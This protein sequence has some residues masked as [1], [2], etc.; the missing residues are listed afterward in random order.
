MS[1]RA[2]DPPPDAP[3][4]RDAEAGEA[5]VE[6]YRRLAD[7]FHD[8]LSEQSL[9]AFLERIADT[10]AEL[11]P[12]DDLAIYEADEARR[13]LRAVFARGPWADEVLADAPFRFGEG[14][15]GWAVEHREPLLVNRADLDPRVRFV[16]NT[17][18]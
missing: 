9:D 7:V 16:E 15:T 13:E 10:V 14:I 4:A 6:S 8:V 2:H 5:L 12:H 1:A 3:A 11:I 17:P 18:S